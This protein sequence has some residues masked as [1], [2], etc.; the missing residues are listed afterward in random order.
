[1]FV[2]LTEL[3]KKTFHISPKIGKAL[4]TARL[5]MDRSI[6]RIEQKHMSAALKDQKSAMEGLNE[7]AKLMLGAMNEMQESGSASGFE[8]FLEQMEQMSQQQQGINQGT[9]QLGQMGMMAQQQMMQ[10]LQAQQ[11]QLQKSLGELLDEMSDGGPDGLGKASQDMEEVVKDF[12][13]RQV[14]RRTMERQE[15][16]LSRMLDSQKSLSQRDY[17]EKRKSEAAE[18][19]I[20]TGSSGL[21]DNMGERE[22]LL[23]Q[24]MEDALNEGHSR[25]YQSM[26]KTYFRKL[27]KESDAL[28]NSP[29]NQSNE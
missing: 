13:R 25:E 15:R 23:I 8:S 17:S 9:M 7:A 5:S 4:G 22:M 18:E 26:M 11:Q 3:S 1:L 20:Y 16:I 21:P 24:A 6:G 10:K 14:D 28:N 29:E 19:I 2:Q 27:Q 12:K